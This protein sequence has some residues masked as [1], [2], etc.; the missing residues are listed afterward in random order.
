MPTKCPPQLLTGISIVATEQAILKTSSEVA[1]TIDRPD[2][3]T[4]TQNGQE[5]TLTPVG[6]LGTV[7]L[8]LGTNKYVVSIVAGS[9]NSIKIGVVNE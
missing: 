2:L 8:K 1:Y 4:I 6:L 9:T 5:Y 7:N 3:L